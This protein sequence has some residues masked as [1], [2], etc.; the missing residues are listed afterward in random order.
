LWMESLE[1]ARDR[2]PEL[3]GITVR[4]GAILSRRAIAGCA[5][6]D[7]PY[8]RFARRTLSRFVAAHELTHLLQGVPGIPQTV[9]R[10]EKTCDLHV[11]ARAPELIDSGWFYLKL[12]YSILRGDGVDQKRS[13]VR[14]AMRV[15]LHRLAGEAL[16]RRNN[17]LRGYIEW[18]ERATLSLSPARHQP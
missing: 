3:D 11:M 12:P 1:F 17:G 15:E 10:G 16:E 7:V 6:V 2:F 5:A 9:P 14:E 8:V 18:F 13:M 4:V